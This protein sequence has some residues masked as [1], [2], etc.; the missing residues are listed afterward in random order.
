MSALPVVRPLPVR[1]SAAVCVV[2]VLAAVP[3]AKVLPSTTVVLPLSVLAPVVVVKAPDELPKS[4]APLL[5]AATVRLLFSASTVLPFR[6][7]VPD[8]VSNW[9]DEALKLN[10]DAVPPAVKL[11]PSA[12]TVLPLS[13]TCPPPVENVLAPPVCEKLPAVVM[14][15]AVLMLP[16]LLTLNTDDPPSLSSTK[17]PVYPAAAL[18][19]RPVPPPPPSASSTAPAPVYAPVAFT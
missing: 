15:P 14:P 7:T 10:T 19:S 11:L 2:S 5:P 18:I 13:E 12:S 16:A 4:I 6:L 8:D 1:T 3:T 9:L 17:F